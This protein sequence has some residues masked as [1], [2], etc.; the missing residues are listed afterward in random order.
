METLEDFEIFFYSGAKITKTPSDLKIVNDNGMP[1]NE[2]VTMLSGE[3][4]NQHE[5][6]QICLQ[7]CIMLNNTL[8]QMSVGTETCFP[9]IIGR[10]PSTEAPGHKN[11]MRENS[12]YMFST[13]KS[14]Q[15]SAYNF[16][17]N[18]V[19]SIQVK[20]PQTNEN[21]FIGQNVP[22]KKVSIP[23]VGTATELSQGVILIQFYD[24]SHLSVIP[25]RQG[26]GITYTQVGGVATHFSANDD[27]P[28]SVREKYSHFPTVLK[29][30]KGETQKFSGHSSSSNIVTST[31]SAPMRFF[32]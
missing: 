2:P 20:N 9:I 14:Q 5:H 15:N 10:R 32:R 24:G 7:H 11:S 12:S 26:G 28:L 13:P 27:L 19:S 6:F 8:S 16:S 29:H 3:I 18:S 4:A 31:P 30:L 23:G 17:V 21:D 25:Q 1:I 22:I